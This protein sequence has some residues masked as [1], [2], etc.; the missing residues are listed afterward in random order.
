MTNA[1]ERLGAAGYQFYEVSNASRPGKH[2][3]H[4]SAYWTGLPY[5][6]LGP[7]AHS[8][9]G[10]ARRWN[11][12]AWEAYRTAIAAGKSP[13]ESEETLTDD[14]RE[15]ERLYL[16]LR[17]SAGLPLAAC[18]PA[19]ASESF[20]DRVSAWVAA[21]WAEIAGERVSLR[22]TGWLVLDALVRD[23]TGPAR[24]A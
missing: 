8:F 15:L 5:V 11:V 2:S 22:P 10:R 18:P 24:V 7:A 3:R 23:L 19:S 14:Q 9:D 13:I 21:G 6:G 4:N 20:R 12:P 16:G 17:T 1:Y